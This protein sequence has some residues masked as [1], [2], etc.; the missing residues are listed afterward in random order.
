MYNRSN[1]KSIMY[2]RWARTHGGLFKIRN[3]RRPT[4]RIVQLTAFTATEP[5]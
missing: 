2:V 5:V 4:K 3:E 1:K